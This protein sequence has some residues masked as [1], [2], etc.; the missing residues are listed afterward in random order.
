[1]LGNRECC[2]QVTYKNED[3]QRKAGEQW[4]VTQNWYNLTGGRDHAAELKNL[5]SWASV[6]VSQKLDC[7]WLAMKGPFSLLVR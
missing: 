4:T 1:M 5:K 2:N 7:C 3:V 6:C